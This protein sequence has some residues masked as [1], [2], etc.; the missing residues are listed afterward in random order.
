MRRVPV[1]NYD[2]LPLMPTKASRA[3]RWLRDGKA[4]VYPNDLGIFA[5]QLV[6][7]AS[8]N[9]TQDIVAGVDPGKSY[10]GIGVQSA[11]ATHFKAHVILPF[12]RVKKRMETRAILRR[13]R[14]GRRIDRTVPNESR[15]HREKRFD[16]RVQAKLP[17]S[18]RA[19]RQLELRIIQE[20]QKLFPITAV[21][22][23]YVKARTEQNGKGFSP[24]MVGQKAMLEWL[25]ALV[26]VKTQFGWETSRLRKHL[27]LSKTKDKAALDPA[28]HANDGIALAASHFM[29]Y[30]QVQDT[31]SHGHVWT[32][33]VPLTDGPF[34]II[35]RPPLYRRQ[36]HFENPQQGNTRKRKGGTVTPW[37]LRSGDF[38]QAKRAGKTLRGWIGGYTEKLKLVSIY[39]AAW[40][41]LG[42]F[43]LS[44]VQLLQR[45]TGLCV[46]A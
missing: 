32:G 2:G 39:D 21:V 9:E 4:K 28:A 23:E 26:T 8:G 14:R 43:A 38:V 20:L 22:Y 10:S 44:K 24:V 40:K 13:A 30:R 35:Q 34:V 16:N 33:T 7:P 31:R 11:K 5:I 42:Q 46:T 1:I 6:A 15:A 29:A 27:G 17:P 36:L 25:S 41:R 12:S 19:N 37:G 45:S 18:I 3:R